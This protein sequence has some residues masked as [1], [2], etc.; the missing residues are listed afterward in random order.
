MLPSTRLQE[1]CTL[2]ILAARELR[3]KLHTIWLLLPQSGF[4]KHRLFS[5]YNLLF[6]LDIMIMDGSCCFWKFVKIFF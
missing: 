3:N 2:F 5:P 6:F 4:F 1:L